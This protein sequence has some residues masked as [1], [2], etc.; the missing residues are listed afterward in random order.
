M[1][2]PPPD[3]KAKSREIS[4]GAH[5]DGC[6]FLSAQLHAPDKLEVTRCCNQAAPPVFI[7]HWANTTS[8]CCFV[9][10]KQQSVGDQGSKSGLGK[11]ECPP[12]DPAHEDGLPVVTYLSASV[13]VG[14]VV[15]GIVAST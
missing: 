12:V 13:M 4:L 5:A 8:Q 7:G 10:T 1:A 15:T 2:N 3:S 11:A 6:C 9:S 14:V